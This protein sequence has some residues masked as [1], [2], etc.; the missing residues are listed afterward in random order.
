MAKLTDT[1]TGG[2]EKSFQCQATFEGEIA[3]AV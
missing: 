1:E 3:Q 2:V